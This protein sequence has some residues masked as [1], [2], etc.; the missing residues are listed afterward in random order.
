[1]DRPSGLGALFGS[2]GASTLWFVKYVGDLSLF[3]LSAMSWIFRA[4]PKARLAVDQMMEIGYNSTPV[5]ALTALATGS[6]LALQS[7]HGFQRFGAESMVGTVVALS[8]TR[9][10]GPM[11]TAIMVA[12]RAGSAMAAELGAMR[13]T[14]QIDALLALSTDPIKYLVTPRFIATVLALPMLTALA[15]VIGIIGGALIAI[16]V[17]DANSVIYFEN[18]YQFM[19]LNDIYSGLFKSA[20]FGMIVSLVSCHQ[21]FNASG[22]AEGVGLA[23]TRAVVGSSILIFVSD[24]VLTA[25][26]FDQ[27]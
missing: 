21:G 2:I 6:V 16:V 23:T 22:G 1:M 3:G 9:E 14:E 26:L 20:F 27:G 17:L 13:V 24:Y 12:A 18:T 19:R 15:D 10:L 11:L 4:R 7:Y 5:V 8:M 25:F